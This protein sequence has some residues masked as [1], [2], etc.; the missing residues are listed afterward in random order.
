MKGREKCVLLKHISRF[1]FSLCPY[2]LVRGGS[3]RGECKQTRTGL[4][5]EAH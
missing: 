4:P 3:F 2:I 1:S 5:V